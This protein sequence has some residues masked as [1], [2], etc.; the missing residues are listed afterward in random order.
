MHA[1]IDV[2]L[3]GPGGWGGMSVT[4]NTRQKLLS[5]HY[6]EEDF[7]GDEALV[8]LQSR[9]PLVDHQRTY[10]GQI[11]DSGSHQLNS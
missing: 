11:V 8:S 1:T 4:E 7:L 9:S 3:G 10:I 2:R 5:N 6:L